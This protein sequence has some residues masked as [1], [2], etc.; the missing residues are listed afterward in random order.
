MVR[1][2][3][4]IFPFQSA[5]PGAMRA[6]R[7]A[8]ALATVFVAVGVC[9]PAQAARKVSMEAEAQA[10]SAGEVRVMVV[11]RPTPAAMAAMAKGQRLYPRVDADVGAVLRALPGAGA[12]RVTRRFARVPAFAM[13]ADMA[14]LARLQRD[15][16]VAKVD[17]D[18]GGHV[19]AAQV[20]DASVLNQV[21]QLAELG[22][23]GAGMT[24]A[25]IDSGIATRHTDFL[26]RIV[27]EQCFCSVGTGCCPNGSTSQSGAGSAEDDHGHGTN[28]AGI[29]GGAGTVA[30]RGA[31]P[32][33]QLIAV[34][35]LD[36]SGRFNST[37]DIV[38]ALDWLATQHPEVDAVNL[39]LGTD[40]LLSGD[41]DGNAAW[42]QALA[43][44]V[45]NL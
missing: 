34:K 23:G 6:L 18:P 11:L 30:P 26:G 24:A 8:G 2:F 16:R 14:T 44:A 41:C 9:A 22:V 35:V 5:V 13:R 19:D 32:Q 28:V 40:T 4:K 25:V 15:P 7:F 43:I 38:A 42:T 29:I 21:H 20:D 45:H 31:L 33:A 12:A 36:R 3:D 17:I 1:I 27:G 37:S 39:S 10:R